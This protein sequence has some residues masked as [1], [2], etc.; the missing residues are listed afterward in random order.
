M[1]YRNMTTV[2]T[3]EYLDVRPNG[4][5]DYAAMRI[6]QLYDLPNALSDCM[7]CVICS[8]L[9]SFFLIFRVS[10]ELISVI[11]VHCVRSIL[12]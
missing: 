11:I 1:Q 7:L 12:M 3:R 9:L 4:W 8:F 6:A 10:G 5:L 2:L